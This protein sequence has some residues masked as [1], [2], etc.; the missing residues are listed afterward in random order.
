MKYFL[1]F[2]GK[3]FGFAAA[4]FIALMILLY[5]FPINYTASMPFGIYMRLPAWNV[6]AGDLV[7]LDNPLPAE[8]SEALGVYE[9]RGLLKR[10]K[11]INDDGTYY[12]LGEHELSY[13][14]RYFGNVDKE[15]IRWRLVPVFTGTNLPEWLRADT[16][17]EI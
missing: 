15:L 9:R 17:S 12:V 4:A 3:V 16:D 11:S 6:K 10:V 5:I 1:K 2:A 13:D 7:E 8:E 14:S